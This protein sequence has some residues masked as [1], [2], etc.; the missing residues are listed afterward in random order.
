MTSAAPGLSTGQYTAAMDKV[1]KTFSTQE[2]TLDRRELAGLTERGVK[3][4]VE[5]K[6]Q[7]QL[8]RARAAF[9]Q[10]FRNHSKV[11][12]N[13]MKKLR[14][15]LTA[16]LEERYGQ[17]LAELRQQVAESSALVQ[18]H[19]DE[20][21][22]LKRLATAQEAYVSAVRH[23]W[24]LETK[25]RL[26]AEI[27]SLKG[28][29]ERRKQEN[30]DL[31]HQ[32]LC[33]DELVAQ[34]GSELSALEGELKQQASAFAEEKRTYEEKLRSL[35]L[36][37][38][39]QQDEFSSTLKNY[40]DQFNEYR[41]KTT[42]E[43]QIQDILNSRRSEALQQMEEERQ[44]H[45]K[46]RTKPSDRIGK[47]FQTETDEEHYEPYDLAKNVR[48][49]VD[50]MGMDTSWRDYQLKDSLKPIPQGGV[51]SSS[52]RFRVERYTKPP[53]L[54]ARQASRRTSEIDGALG[55]PL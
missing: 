25:E 32:L 22:Q 41:S 55:L 27:D 43:L 47:T 28:E 33:R 30:A 50:N 18:K 51:K 19:V 21:S 2:V 29:V 52:P 31:S 16:S 10:E 5:Q 44:R 15:E 38:R 36:E 6:F 45:I 42:A 12:E 39:Q 11:A 48:Y 8:L 17:K 9:L 24:G 4:F 49:R 37:M 53:P 1:Y 34:L 3:Q 13:D 20:I 46:A 54:S 14:E 26:R 23:R 40:E 7:D 35:R